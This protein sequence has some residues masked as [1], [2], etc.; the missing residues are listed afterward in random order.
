M[1]A[2]AATPVP[3]A[4]PASADPFLRATEAIDW[5]R[6]EI[7]ALARELRGGSTDVAAIA[8]SCFEWVRDRIE[9]CIDYHRD[10]VTYR[11]SDALSVGTGFCYAK[12]HLLVALLRA[13][14]IRAGLCYQ[15][16][17]RD[18][19]FQATVETRYCLHGLAAVDLGDGRWYRI[20]PRG[21]KPGV[22]AQ[23]T[24][25]VERLAFPTVHPGEVLFPSVYADP[26]PSIKC[27]LRTHQ[28]ASVVAESLPD[29]T[30]EAD[31]EAQ[32]PL[33]S[34]VDRTAGI[35]KRYSHGRN[36]LTP[37]E[38]QEEFERGV[39]EQGMESMNADDV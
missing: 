33:S 13:N 34:V 9:H 19:A 32:A 24:P 35:V 30:T 29:A 14:G 4:D 23:F 28:S 31:L 8:R 37:L 26:V 15:R 5:T 27:A 12:A 18:D 11:A 20:D 17:T 39:A 2:A 16:L 3:S 10:E 25:P 6:P 21:N 36:P 22:D 1:D 7:Q 38:E